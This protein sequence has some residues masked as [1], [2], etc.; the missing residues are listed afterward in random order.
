AR[1]ARAP[2][3]KWLLV[4]AGVF[5]LLAAGAVG[6][7]VLH[8][9]HASRDVRG[10]PTVEFTPTIA[11]PKPIP[12]PPPKAKPG[13][14]AAL[15]RVDWPFCGYDDARLRWVPSSLHPPFRRAWT[16]RARKLVEFPPV[17]AYGRLFVA[18]N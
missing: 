15:V 3:R 11:P 7:Y 8:V 13:K 12:K 18:N 5:V 6:G 2:V 4:G 9:K 17:I 1:V 10:S 16:F 14:P